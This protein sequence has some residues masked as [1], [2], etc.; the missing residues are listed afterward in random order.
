M[1][2]REKEKQRFHA[3]CD[4]G[5]ESSISGIGVQGGTQR[6]MRNTSLEGKDFIRKFPSVPE[7]TS[8]SRGKDC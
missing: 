8:A 5:Q 1:V 4:M 6:L 2:S 3:M 7:S